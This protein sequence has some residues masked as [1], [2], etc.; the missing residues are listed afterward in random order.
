MKFTLW[1][2]PKL[3][4]NVWSLQKFEPFRSWTGSALGG[5]RVGR[6]FLGAEEGQM[7]A[8]LQP[9]Q[10]VRIVQEESQDLEEDTR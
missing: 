6:M 8:Q 10:G 5:L 9:G 1:I 4:R 7:R 3:H 2:F